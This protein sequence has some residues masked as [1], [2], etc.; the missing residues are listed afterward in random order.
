MPSM[1]PSGTSFWISCR[2]PVSMKIFMAFPPLSRRLFHPGGRRAA[3]ARLVDRDDLVSVAH[4]RERRAIGIPRFLDWLRRQRL[5]CGTAGLAAQDDV[6]G[7]IR[8]AVRVP[9]QVHHPG[10]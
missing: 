3:V 10:A 5:Q 7:E 1:M 2:L 8:L 4:A 9:N 6:A